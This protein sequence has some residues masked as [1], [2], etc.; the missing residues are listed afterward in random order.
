MTK[1]A[2]FCKFV[3]E[4]STYTTQIGAVSQSQVCVISTRSAGS[5]YWQVGGV[6][7]WCVIHLIGYQ[8]S[9]ERRTLSELPPRLTQFTWATARLAKLRH[10]S[11]EYH[12]LRT[13]PYLDCVFCQVMVGFRM[14][15]RIKSLYYAIIAQPLAHTNVELF[16]PRGIYIYSFERSAPPSRWMVADFPT[17]LHSIMFW[18]QSSCSL[19]SLL[20][21]D[22]GTCMLTSV[23]TITLHLYRTSSNHR[24]SEK[25]TII[26]TVNKKRKLVEDE[27]SHRPCLH[28]DVFGR[29]RFTSY[30]IALSL[31]PARRYVLPVYTPTW[32]VAFLKRYTLVSVFRTMRLRLPF[33]SFTC[34]RY[35]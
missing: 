1:I 22:T 6:W 27:V 19:N 24:A 32:T 11:K 14:Y 13:W 3:F 18:S 35:A 16:S 25:T 21:Q 10:F 12:R 9:D 34:K 15:G 26:G 28:E 31:R 2:W 4:S 20:S 29:K 7:K 23:V 33:L 5:I 17:P 8:T 30:H